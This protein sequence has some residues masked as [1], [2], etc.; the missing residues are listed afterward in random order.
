MNLNAR[1]HFV[2]KTG[3]KWIKIYKW[4]FDKKVKQKCSPELNCSGCW[5]I[6]QKIFRVI[7]KDGIEI[8][9]KPRPI[10]KVEKIVRNTP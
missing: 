7:G 5:K 9:D 10:F 1:R 6:P 3:L 2:E 4:F 8:E